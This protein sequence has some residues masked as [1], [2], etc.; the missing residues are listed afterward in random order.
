MW[1]SQPYSDHGLH[2]WYYR[3]LRDFAPPTLLQH[4]TAH[5]AVSVCCVLYLKH[6]LKLLDP[7]IS[8]AKKITSVSQ[9][10]HELNSYATEHWADHVE[11]VAEQQAGLHLT[12]LD[13]AFLCRSLDD[14]TLRQDDILCL[15]QVSPPTRNS[16]APDA[17]SPWASLD[18]S[19]HTRELLDHSLVSQETIV[20]GQKLASTV[21]GTCDANLETG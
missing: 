12:K 16:T 17:S 4:H 2:S 1:N 7:R 8:E 6:G 11:A 5:V 19:D 14:F 21:D 13:S 20:A 9:A 18:I 3:Y 15:L 10:S